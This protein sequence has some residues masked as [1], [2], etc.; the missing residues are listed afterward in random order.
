MADRPTP[1]QAC[2]IMAA[3]IVILGVLIVARLV[4]WNLYPLTSTSIL[5]VVFNI[6]FFLLIVSTLYSG[7]RET[8]EAAYTLG[9]ILTC[10]FMN[11]VFFGRIYASLEV[12]NGSELLSTRADSIYFSVIT[13]TTLGYGDFAPKSSARVIA[14]IQV[15]YGYILMPLIVAVILSMLQP[16]KLD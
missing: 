3:T 8:K 9:F 7:L 5:L 1:A 15:L 13:W 14:S 6:P 10:V 11:I 16:K 12:S 4:Y 2:Q